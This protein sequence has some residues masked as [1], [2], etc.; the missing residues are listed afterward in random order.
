MLDMP[1]IQPSQDQQ[2]FIYH[3]QVEQYVYDQTAKE[4]FNTLS[5]LMNEEIN[6]EN[7]R[8]EL[9]ALTKKHVELTLDALAKGKPVYEVMIKSENEIKIK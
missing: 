3:P 1:M 4:V 9:N 7:Y 2:F 8:Q 5:K 6:F